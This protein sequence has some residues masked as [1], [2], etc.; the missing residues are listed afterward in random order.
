M[1]DVHKLEQILNKCD[2]EYKWPRPQVSDL[3]YE[4]L[5]DPK[6]VSLNPHAVCCM[7]PYPH[8]LS[9]QPLVTLNFTHHC[10]ALVNKLKNTVSNRHR[11]KFEEI[12]ED[13]VAFKMVNE[14]GTEVS[15]G[16]GQ[17]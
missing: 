13:I 12:S 11:Y 6:L 4:T 1:D 2:E 7:Y 14:N 16:M 10:Q 15:H 17:R 8:P 3:E 5:Y 9:M